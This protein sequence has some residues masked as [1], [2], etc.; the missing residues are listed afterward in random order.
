MKKYNYLSSSPK[1]SHKPDEIQPRPNSAQHI[2]FN[3]TKLQHQDLTWVAQE[4]G[5]RVHSLSLSLSLFGRGIPARHRVRP[6]APPNRG[7]LLI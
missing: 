5:H 4:N 3:A 7:G 2:N 1:T 6:V